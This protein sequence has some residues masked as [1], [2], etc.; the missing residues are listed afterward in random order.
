MF[1]HWLDGIHVARAFGEHAQLASW[2]GGPIYRG[3][4]LNCLLLV[5]YIWT[6]IYTYTPTHTHAVEIQHAWAIPSKLITEGYDGNI[7][8]SYGAFIQLCSFLSIFLTEWINEHITSG[9]WSLRIYRMT[10]AEESNQARMIIRN[11]SQINS[12]E[13]HAYFFESL[14]WSVNHQKSPFFFAD[15]TLRYGRIPATAIMDLKC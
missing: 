3:R 11:I 15:A 2:S 7:S 5:G 6:C 13:I 12:S 9:R 8:I 10:K 1:I 14:L 4:V